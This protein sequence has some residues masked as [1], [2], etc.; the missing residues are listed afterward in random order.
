MNLNYKTSKDYALLKKLLDEGKHVI[1]IRPQI[2]DDEEYFISGIV[3]KDYEGYNLYDL[4]LFVPISS[5]FIFMMEH[6]KVEF[7][8]PTL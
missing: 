6:Y 2:I 3:Y 4:D 1:C 5:R 7:I 8:E